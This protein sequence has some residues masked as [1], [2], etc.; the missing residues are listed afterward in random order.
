L[1]GKNSA[2]LRSRFEFMRQSTGFISLLL[3]LIFISACQNSQS[4]NSNPN[5]VLWA[6]ERPENL[7]FIDNSQ[8]GVAF[9]AQ[10]IELNSEKT[11]VKFRRQPLKVPPN[12]KLIAVTRI[13]TQKGHNKA[14]LSDLQHRE[15]LRL[16]LKSLELKNVSG[17][18]I[19]FDVTVTEREF[20]R[21][22]LLDLRSKLPAH[23]E[24]TMTALASWCESDNWIKDL[25]VDEAIPMAFEMGADNK[26]IRDFLASGEDWK[27]PL[28][29]KSYGISVNEPLKIKFRPNRKFYLFNYNP[30][31]WKKSD[32]ENLPD[33]IGL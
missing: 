24:L 25:P 31:G 11:I 19:D 8:I 15:I 9:L 17:I 13:E 1:L 28:C 16:I 22:I 33:G 3:W 7:E 4:I 5:I 29:Q 12:T 21:V 23:I 18:Q 2:K 10:T 27:E 14:V 20:Y 30:N 6:W 32:L 26:T